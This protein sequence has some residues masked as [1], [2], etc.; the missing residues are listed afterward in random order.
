MISI[1]VIIIT[2][3]PTTRYYLKRKRLKAKMEFEPGEI[4]WG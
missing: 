3:I 2:M 1:L 4:N